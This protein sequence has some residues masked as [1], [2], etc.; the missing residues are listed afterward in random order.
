[1]GWYC[2]RESINDDPRLGE[3]IGVALAKKHLGI[4]LPPEPTWEE[5]QVREEAEANPE[6]KSELV[7]AGLPKRGVEFPE[8]ID[9]FEEEIRKY[10][11]LQRF[12]EALGAGRKGE[13]TTLVNLLKNLGLALPE[14][15]DIFHEVRGTGAAGQ[16]G[17]T[18][19][20]PPDQS[21]AQFPIGQD[22]IHTVPSVPMAQAATPSPQLAPDSMPAETRQVK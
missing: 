12:R 6:Y 1:M 14:I 19:E 4:E 10:Q 17:P 3:A 8:D 22:P 21:Q 18:L 20:A 5:K 2:L 11:Q 15:V 7:K 16:V 13:T 9:P